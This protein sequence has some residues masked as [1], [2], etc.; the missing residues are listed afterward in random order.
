MFRQPTTKDLMRR[1]LLLTATA[2]LIPVAGSVGAQATERLDYAML[3]RIRE[4]ALQRSQVMD[5]MSWLSDVK[6]PR[7]TGSP[8]FR[9]AGNWAI[10]TMGK[11]GLSG[12]RLDPWKFGR[13]WSLERF[14]A[15][16]IEPQIQ[17]LI[18]YPKA[19]TPGTNGVVTGEVVHAVITSTAD[20]ERFRG[21][22]RGRIVLSQPARQVNLL[23]GD[24]VLRMDDAGLKEAQS[25]PI[26][27]APAPA[28]SAPAAPP[29]SQAQ[30]MKFW[31]DEGVVAVLDRGSDTDMFATGSDLSMITQRTDGGTV[32][33]GSGGSRDSG[34][35]PVPPQVTLAV[36]H[37]NRMVRILDRAVPVRIE[38]DIRARFHEETTPNGFNIIA[39]IPGTDPALRD[40]VVM[41]GAHFD[42]WH[43]GTG[44]TDNA[45][46]SAVMM[47]A[48]RVLKTL[49]VRPRRT[50]RI[51]LWGGEEQGLL[52]SRAYVAKTFYDAASAAR[53]AAYEK[54]SGYFN[55]DNG[56]GRIRG[57][58]TQQ[59]FAVSPI[60]QAW[61][62]PLSDLGVGTI[63]PRSVGST[64][65][66]PFDAAGL[67]GFQFIQDR[68][69]YQ[70]RT[71]HSNMDVVDRVQREDLMQMATVVSWFAFNAAM[72]DEKLPRKAPPSARVAQ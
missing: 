56:T 53:Q 3:G 37:Y 55:I 8:A 67:P 4:E 47:E 54:L 5:L 44:A 64:D 66:V 48:M 70:S 49:G 26:P 23:E 1:S 2:F 69:E 19:W 46:G 72:R 57:V 18:G 15:H 59:N 63:G 34:G 29:V 11:W 24:I 27:R 14:S 39:E 61:M 25:T 71:H 7:L 32:F 33:V 58:W 52:G 60:F 20:L 22:L 13:G 42:S 62:A 51:A 65:H 10:E 16:M 31:M 68:L 36:E 45:A 28:R 43:S 6:G 12:A 30:L 50:I 21:K 41:I 35:P 9:D 38:L 17:P 40:E